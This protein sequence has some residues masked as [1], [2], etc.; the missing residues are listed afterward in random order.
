MSARKLDKFYTKPDVVQSLLSQISLEDYDT[1]LEPSAG[2][3]NF[4]NILFQYGN[5]IAIDIDPDNEYI[6]K[7]DFLQ[8]FLIL[9]G[10]T[11]AIGNPPFGKQCSLAIKF[12]NKAASYHNISTI[13]FI[14]PKSFKKKSLQN[15]LDRNFSLHSSTDLEKFSF[16]LE[17]KDYDVPTIFQI[18]NRTETPR[19]KHIKR[20]LENPNIS[21]IKYKD[22]KDSV[23]AVRR[24]GINAGKSSYFDNQSKES[25]YFLK[26]DN[27]QEVIDYLNNI[28]WEHNDTTGP[29]SISKQ[30][31]IEVL[32]I[33]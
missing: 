16:L 10:N 27:L 9:E 28:Y 13:A 7:A 12:F 21:F 18:W 14:L 1:I 11:I 31:F 4:S 17:D 30:Q 26:C 19:P 5:L 2:S 20:T 15:K 33:M 6:Q 22:I 25:H 3:G 8:D 29:R 23:V 24:V 32:N